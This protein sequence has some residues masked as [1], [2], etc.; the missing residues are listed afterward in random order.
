MMM[1]ASTDATNTSSPSP[2]TRAAGTILVR[3]VVPLWV[4]AGA[5]VKLWT[6]NP[7]LLPEPILDLVKDTAGLFGV[8]DLGW[9]L[10]MWLRFFIGA[11]FAAVL[12]MFISP[13]LARMVA[14]FLLAIF[15]AVLVATMAKSA[16]RDGISAIWSGSCGCF[17][18]AS[19]PPI[20]M[21]LIDGAMLIGV[22][23][24]RPCTRGG[25]RPV[26]VGLSILVGFG[27][28]YGRPTPVITLE[29]MPAPIEPT[30]ATPATTADRDVPGW[31]DIPA[32]L[33][34]F[35][36]TEFE[37]WVGQ[38]L[39]AQPLARLISRPLPDGIDQGRYHLIFYRTDCEH[40]HALMDDFFSGPLSTP[41]L[42]VK[43]PDGDPAQ[44]LGMPCD[45]CRLHELPSGTQYVIT[46]PVLLTVEDG[47]V[48]AV[49]QDTDDQALVADTIAAN[50]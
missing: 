17:G 14:S 45:E 46:T 24:L 36:V 23:F 29:P 26:L 21:F 7:A 20:G 15:L 34:P 47:Q 32:V 10:E 44:D 40:C 13:R 27:L 39:S 41:T 2:K 50:R 4:L 43:I 3:I 35:Y 31:G 8:S 22:I 5:S 12:I 1:T 19:P 6:F 11:E 48:I 33:E 49:C 30:P 28:A 18:S 9:W 42:A 16:Q 38:P 37:E 25:L